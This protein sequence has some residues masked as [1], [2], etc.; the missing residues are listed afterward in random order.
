VAGQGTEEREFG[1]FSHSSVRDLAQLVKGR[2]EMLTMRPATVQRILAALILKPHRV[3]YCL[4]RTDPWFEEKRAEI[5]ELDLHPPRNCRILWLEEKTH[6]QALERWYPPLPMRPGGVERQE[7]EYLRHG[8]V[9]LFA[10]FAVGTGHVFAQCYPRH[11]NREFR[12]FLRAR[13]SRAPDSRWHR[14]VDNAGFPKKQEGRDWCA[15]QRP[16]VTRHWLPT[17]GSWRNQVEIWFSILS[18]K[19]RRRAR[20]RSTQ[21]LRD[22]IHR[23]SKTWNTPFAH[24]FEWPYTGTPLAI[25]PAHYALLAA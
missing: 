24:P 1:G 19:C 3:R 9:D 25:A 18:R 7:G 20:V 14:I 8:T 5:L 12:H 23:F 15:A 2:G 11:T 10:A 21:D 16:Q 6:S 22:L 4:T 13:R 17:P